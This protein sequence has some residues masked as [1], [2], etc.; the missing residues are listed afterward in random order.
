MPNSEGTTDHEVENYHFEKGANWDVENVKTILQ[1]IHI[2]A[3]NLDVMTEA[4]TH[5]KRYIRRNTIISLILSTLASTASLS[6][7]GGVG[8]SWTQP[9]S[10]VAGARLALCPLLLWK[11]EGR[12]LL[13][14]ERG[15]A[16]APFLL[17]LTRGQ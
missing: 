11:K 6:Q 7:S 4:N 5:Y 9:F 13:E 2:A 14:R 10:S 16:I 3:I 17:C 1:W 8:S 12:C 15:W